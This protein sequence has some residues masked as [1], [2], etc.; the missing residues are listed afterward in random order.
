MSAINTHLKDALHGWLRRSGVCIPK[1][2]VRGGTEFESPAF[3]DML[4]F[5]VK[6]DI[7]MG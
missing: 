3:C 6:V 7:V 4:P 5:R 1:F 2:M